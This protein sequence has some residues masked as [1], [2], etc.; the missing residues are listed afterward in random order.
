M[1]SKTIRGVGKGLAM[2]ED[3]IFVAILLFFFF[4][5][6]TRAFYFHLKSKPVWKF[7]WRI[8]SLWVS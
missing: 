3:R 8:V 2:L 4:H 1:L 7:Y 5:Y 6:Y